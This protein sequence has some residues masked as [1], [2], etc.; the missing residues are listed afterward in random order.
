M[1]L[2]S[3]EDAHIYLISNIKFS[4]YDQKF[5]NN[6]YTNYIKKS[7]PLSVN[8][9]VLWETIVKKYKTQIYK[10][11]MSAYDI[12]KLPWQQPVATQN[13]I[14]SYLKVQDNIMYLSFPF[15]KQL[16]T[17]VRALVFDDKQGYINAGSLVESKYDF[18]WDKEAG[19]WS[20]PF[21]VYLF[22]QLYNVAKKQGINIDST[23]YDLVNGITSTKEEWTPSLKIVHGSLY[24]NCIADSMMN[25][26][27][28][29]DLSD[30]SV[31]NMELLCKTFG[32][33][34]P[35]DSELGGTYDVILA[36][37]TISDI[38]TVCEYI[39]ATNRKVAILHKPSFFI[40]K[41][42]AKLLSN[43]LKKYGIKAKTLKKSADL[44]PEITDTVITN[45]LS[46]S[47]HNFPDSVKIIKVIL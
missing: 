43:E 28:S 27:K 4:R 31:A 21:N 40:K 2:N 37:N 18:T 11:N 5:I 12:I 9:N 6:I 3:R 33:H 39:K 30:T 19:F 47:Y 36:I 14:E 20:G 16:I 13:D 38:K 32:L 10:N 46:V 24:I 7:R 35:I 22:K 45:A 29:F 25:L 1:I 34:P 17:E 23:V 41:E 15:N 42:N 44:D 8:Q 26:L